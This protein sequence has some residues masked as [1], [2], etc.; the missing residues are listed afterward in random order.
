MTS[1]NETRIQRYARQIVLPEVGGVGQERLLNTRVLIVGAGGLGCPLALY[2]AGSGI[3]HI[4]IVDDD[5]VDESNLHRQIAFPEAAIGKSKA[6]ILEAQ[7]RTINSE[8]AVSSIAD[9]LDRH[10]AGALIGSFD[11][12]ADGSDN[13]ETRKLV[14]DTAM[15]LGKPLVSAAVQGMDGQLTVYQAFLGPPH[16]CL[17]CQH[18]GETDETLLP[19]CAG[20][21]VL[22]PVAGVMGTLQA[23]EIAKLALG[24]MQPLS[25]AMLIY[26]ARHQDI[27]TITL[28]R[29]DN[30]AFCE[31]L[32]AL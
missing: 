15:Q 12:I 19:S 17:Y 16:P 26:D 24:H 9:R 3:G 30:C 10:N 4:G 31:S 21:G 32:S 7:V 20:G 25:G 22:G 6:K 29:S 23:V 5:V 28:P 2:L 8:C 13:L 11:I 1:L 14:H 18:A 27:L